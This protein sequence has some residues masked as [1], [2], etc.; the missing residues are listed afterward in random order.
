MLIA[1]NGTCTM[2]CSLLEDI[3]VAKQ[4]GFDAIEIIGP[5]LDKAI[6]L[7]YSIEFVKRQLDGF[8]VVALGYILDIERQS[9]EEHAA[10]IRE[11]DKRLA[12]AHE[13][14]AEYV[15]IVTGPLGPGLGQT[16][17]YQG[18]VGRSID[19]VVELTAKNVAVLADM[20]AER[21]IRLYLESLAW[22]PLG[23]LHDSLRMIDLVGRENVG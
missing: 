17:G 9:P 23:R 22:T 8:P 7:G 4:A 13:L 19:E 16:G 1:H 2:N 3:R 5:K 18:L 12:Q 21:N 20:A 14:G 11:A 10:L 6:S 15:E